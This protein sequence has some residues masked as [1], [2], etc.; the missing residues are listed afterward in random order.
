LAP[1]PLEEAVRVEDHQSDTQAKQ[2]IASTVVSHSK[3][4]PKRRPERDEEEDDERNDSRVAHLC[5]RQRVDIVDER[6][7]LIP[8]EPTAGRVSTKEQLGHERVGPDPER[9]LLQHQRRSDLQPLPVLH[10]SGSLLGAPGSDL[11]ECNRDERRGED[12]AD[13]ANPGFA[14]G[15]P[16][17]RGAEEHERAARTEEQQGSSRHGEEGGGEGG[18]RCQLREQ[19]SRA[20]EDERERR[21][22]DQIQQDAEGVLMGE[23]PVGLEEPQAVVLPQHQNTLVDE[24]ER[25]ATEDRR[26]HRPV[27]ACSP[28]GREQEVHAAEFPRVAEREHHPPRLGGGQESDE[29]VECE[30]ESVRQ[31]FGGP[32]VREPEGQDEPVDDLDLEAVRVPRILCKEVEGVAR[33]GVE[34][35]EADQRPREMSE[36][37]AFSEPSPRRIQTQSGDDED[38]PLHGCADRIPRVVYRKHEY[39][40]FS[41]GPADAGSPVPP[42]SFPGIRLDPSKVPSV[43]VGPV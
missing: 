35:Q 37:R 29:E 28:D 1:H 22:H 5:R 20:R 10:R 11:A 6:H 13:H 43:R 17:E 4:V 26:G 12:E 30:R 7:P 33:G 42:R 15:V 23:A 34:G 24:P 19:G 8:G 2:N 38:D 27:L 41:V 32:P 39:H 14:N 21:H 9:M 16:P 36:R 3:A 18:D 40:P 31:R 25:H